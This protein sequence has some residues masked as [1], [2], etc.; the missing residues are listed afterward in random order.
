MTAEQLKEQGNL[1]Q[2]FEERL[3]KLQ[4]ENSRLRAALCRHARSGDCGC[5]PCRG[6]CRSQ[7]ALEAEIEGRIEDAR[8]A[9]GVV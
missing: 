3:Q 7:Q 5:V 1:I 8:R 6:Q 2:Y 9:L 4:A